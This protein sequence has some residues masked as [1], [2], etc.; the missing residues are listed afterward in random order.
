M[1]L[2]FVG[3]LCCNSLFAESHF[4]GSASGSAAGAPAYSSGGSAAY[5]GELARGGETLK[6]KCRKLA[7]QRGRPYSVT[8]RITSL[9][10]GAL[11][12]RYVSGHASILTSW[13]GNIRPDRDVQIVPPP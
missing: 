8:I 12:G 9:T 2:F 1:R 3:V 7:A 4:G 5:Y 13:G 11:F 10:D 6:E